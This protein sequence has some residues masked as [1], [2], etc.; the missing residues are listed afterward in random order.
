MKAVKRCIRIQYRT[1]PGIFPIRTLYRCNNCAMLQIESLFPSEKGEPPSFCTH[2]CRLLRAAVLPIAK[3]LSPL[4][5]ASN[6]VMEDMPPR[7]VLRDSEAY[8]L[9]TMKETPLYGGGHEV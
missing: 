5:A 8:L 2:E 9:K 6:E 7:N 4:T 1:V 3:G